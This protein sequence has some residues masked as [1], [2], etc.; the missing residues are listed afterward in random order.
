MEASNVVTTRT[1]NERKAMSSSQ[2][3]R[4][5]ENYAKKTRKNKEVVSVVSTSKIQSL[6]SLEKKAD[7]PW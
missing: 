7:S 1:L 4:R 5:Q 3:E 6:E 2:V